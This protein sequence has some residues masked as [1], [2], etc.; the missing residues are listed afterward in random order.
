[1]PRNLQTL[2]YSVTAAA[3]IAN[4]G[5]AAAVIGDNSFTIQNNNGPVKILAWHA[6]NQTSGFH[7]LTS[8][9]M[10][11]NQNGLKVE[12]AA[13]DLGNLI[14]RGLHL[15]LQPQEAFKMQ[16]SGGAVAGDVESG[17]LLMEYD[18]FPG[19]SGRYIG[20]DALRSRM[21]PSKMTTVFKTLAATG[22]GLGVAEALNSEDDNLW[23]GRDYAL[24]GISCSTNVLGVYI[25]GP[26]TGNTKIACPGNAVDAY[27]RGSDYYCELSRVFDRPCIP[28]INST[29]KANTFVGFYADENVAQPVVSLHFAML[30]EGR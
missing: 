2:A 5:S 27:P 25:Y 10:H 8:P 26:D 4:G 11:D 3:S 24:L 28:V 15:E 6:L 18:D 22:P 30:K 7:R 17:M 1:M 16:I 21:D 14:G 19:S 12:V 29:N 13:G 9:S 23:G 20:F